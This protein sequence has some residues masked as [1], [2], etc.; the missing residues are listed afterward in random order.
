[1]KFAAAGPRLALL[2]FLISSASPA[3]GPMTTPCPIQLGTGPNSY[4]NANLL[5]GLHNGTSWANAYQSLVTAITNTPAGGTIWVAR[6]TYPAPHPFG[7]V[8][9]KELKFY[10]GFKGNELTLQTR[11]GDF[12][13]TVINGTISGTSPYHVVDIVDAPSSDPTAPP[14]TP[15]LVVLDGFAIAG[16]NANGPNPNPGPD[17]CGGGIRARCTNLDL[18]NCFVT[19]NTAFL[20]GGGLYFYQGCSPTPTQPNN[21][22]I[23]NCLFTNVSQYDGGGIY[24]TGVKGHVM[25]TSFVFNSA[26]NWGGGVYLSGMESGAANMLDFT[27]CVFQSNEALGLAGPGSPPPGRGGAIYL[28]TLAGLTGAN[29]G[30]INCTFA[31]NNVND[32]SATTGQAVYVSPTSLCTI[33]NSILWHNY[34]STTNTNPITG[35]PTVDWSDV[36]GGWLG[37]GSNNIASDP[38]F[39][40]LTLG[41]LKLSPTSQCIDHANNT[42]LPLDVLDL[43]DDGDVTE[44]VPLDFI[45]SA[46]YA[47][48]PETDQGTPPASPCL[49]MGAY[50]TPPPYQSPP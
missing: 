34:I 26:I 2:C 8:I 40:S 50:E 25:N 41:G 36:E 16:G 38:L 24:A 14:G 11:I 32:D 42:A 12:A 1:M 46:R 37:T 4:V 21:L 10:G 49:D 33:T 15:G 3:Y 20:F 27:N 17:W 13:G 23:K 5:T 47:L 19:Q 6:G 30:I 7:F 29:V 48:R 45:R 22:N 18:A 35:N 31:Q 28:A 44:K 39:E 43:D 9:N